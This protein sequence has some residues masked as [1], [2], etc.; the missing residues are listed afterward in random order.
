MVASTAALPS[1]V[2]SRA[3]RW[4]PGLLAIVVAVG[5]CGGGGGGSNAH[6]KRAAPTVAP[7]T[8]PA[9]TTTTIP[10]YISFVATVK[11]TLTSIDVYPSPDAPQPGQSFPNPWLYESGNPD[12]KVPQTFLVKSQ[13]PDGWIEVSLP[14][15]P[16]GSVGWVHASDVTLGQNP[17]HIVVSLTFHTIVVTKAQAP[18]YVGPVAVGAP[19][20]PTPTGS[21][22]LYVLL[23]SPDPNGPYGPFAYGLSSHSDALAT[24]DG[25]DA[26]IGIHGNGD[27]SALG[28]SVSHGCVRMDNDAIA[29]LAGQLPLGTPVD[30]K[31]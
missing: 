19:D 17:Y 1:N 21:Y 23:Q 5:A 12:S 14:V 11:P 31:G 28:H 24:F 30:I 29:M 9:P 2:V 8:V 15:R 13:R 4:C 25:G 6:A 22:Y 20:T 3:W 10:A 18:I 16:N 26:E 7:T 27:A